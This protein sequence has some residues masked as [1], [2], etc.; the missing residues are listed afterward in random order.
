MRLRICFSFI[1]RRRG[2]MFDPEEIEVSDVHHLTIIKS[3]AERIDLVNTINQLVPSN[4]EVDPGTVVLAMVLDTLSGRHP[5]YRID[6]FFEH[7]DIELLLGRALDFTQLGDDNCGRVLDR[8]FDANTQ[9]I[10]SQLAIHALRAFEI[11]TRHVHFD[12]TSRLVFGD[13]L[14]AGGELAAPMKIT[15]GYSKDHRPDLNQFLISLLCTGGNVPIFTKLEDGNASDKKI[16]NAVLTDISRTLAKVGMDPR[17]TIYIADAAFVTR[18]N[19]RLAGDTTLFIS[20]LPA[21]YG[22]HQRLI[23]QA[24]A[25]SSWQDYGNLA[26]TKPTKNRPGTDY[27]GRETTVELHGQTYRAVVVHSSAHDRRRQK[28]LQRDIAAELQQWSKTCKELEKTRYFCRADA[29]AAVAR[30]QRHDLACH[31]LDLTVVET[32]RYARGRPRTDGSRTVKAIHYGI[33]TTL[34]ENLRAIAVMK[35]QAGCFVLITNVAPEG[36]PGAATPYDGKAILQAYKDQNGIEHNFSFLKDP[37]LVNAIFLKKPERIEALGLILVI[38]LLLWRLIELSMRQYLEQNQAELPGW[39][40]KPTTRPTT[41]MM[42]TKFQGIQVLKLGQ[43]RWLARKLSEVHKLYLAA[44]GLS[45][46]VFTQVSG[47]DAPP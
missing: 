31:E 43:R 6:S 19:L 30:L 2:A 11:P 27:R 1:K 18:D 34:R 7:K 8:L 38:S 35:E 36:P 41:F 14:A 46:L 23:Q 22:E 33:L 37:V 25:S 10:F 28:R 47:A 32:P 44:L 26:I 4:M 9:R 5:L 3:F 17:G 45:S 39:D 24:V 15:K 13:Y 40:N 21:T 16:N 12:T 29:D 20:R 42:T